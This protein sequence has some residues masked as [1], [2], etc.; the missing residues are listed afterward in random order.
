MT[1]RS[2]LGTTLRFEFFAS[3]VLQDVIKLNMFRSLLL[4]LTFCAAI[5]GTLPAQRATGGA[6]PGG[7]RIPANGGRTVGIGSPNF[8]PRHPGANLRRHRDGFGAIWSPWGWGSDD[9]PWNLTSSYEQP[10]NPAL[11]EVIVVG[12]KEPRPTAATPVE[13]PKIIEVSQSNE[14]ANFTKGL[15]YGTAPAT[16]FVLKNGNQFESCHYLLTAQ[17]LQV[18]VDREPRR[19]PVSDIN[20]DA[21][22]AANR[23]RGIELYVPRDRNTVFLSF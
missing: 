4:A 14:A 11:P 6:R 2:K 9:Y 12:N 22:I 3:G 18:D 7:S 8:F 13:P 19:I 17:F 10:I 21:T 23:Q 5:A 20:V 1:F 16:A 15:A